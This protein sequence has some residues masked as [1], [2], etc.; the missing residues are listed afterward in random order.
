M[1]QTKKN[2]YEILGVASTASL[3]E[4]K[5][6]HR[7]LSFEIMSGKLGL[8]PEECKLQ[9]QVIDI[10]L[11]TLSDPVSR[12][13]YHMQQAAANQVTPT[14]Q[15]KPASAS[16][17][18]EG[19]ALQLA[20]AAEDILKGSVTAIDDRQFQFKAIAQTVG[21]SFRSLKIIL[22]IIV[23]LLVL[24]MVLRMSGCMLT[25]R[26]TVIPPAAVTKAEGKLIVQAYYKKHGVRV[27]N[28]AEVEALEAENRARENARREE[29]FNQQ[30]SED[31][32]QRFI[33][34]SQSNFQRQ[35]LE[36][37]RAEAEAR[38]Q[39]MR[40]REIAETAAMQRQ[41]KAQP[42]YGASEAQ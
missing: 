37:Q 15:T 26:K 4:L 28:R 24:G 39:A 32:A 1:A 10:A 22:R 36:Q 25:A 8:S 9:L 5:A 11:N 2:M 3:A 35:E 18:A 17:G 12:D 29:T 41:Q 13:V 33:E 34:D 19:H 20:M 31:E 27:A 21:A 6:A 7:R 30:K 14:P 42:R 38:Y 16:I 23:L 40:R